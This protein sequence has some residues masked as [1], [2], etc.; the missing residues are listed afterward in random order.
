ME[1]GGP[2][3]EAWSMPTEDGEE[4]AT[5]GSERQEVGARGGSERREV[6]WPTGS[7]RPGAGGE[8]DDTFLFVF[9][10]FGEL[11]GE[12]GTGSGDVGITPL[13]GATPWYIFAV[14][15]RSPPA[16]TIRS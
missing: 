16:A 8:E 2:G 13:P 3:E 10:F 5:M 4:E 7:E 12:V 15:G 9:W 6:V 1:G 11:V 14:E